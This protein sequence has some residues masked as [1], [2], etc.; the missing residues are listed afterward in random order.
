MTSRWQAAW[1]E[2][3]EAVGEHPHELS[4]LWLMGF[5]TLTSYGIARP[6]AESLFLEAYTSA[7]LPHVWVA[8]ALGAALVVAGYN[9]LAQRLALDQ[10]FGVVVGAT[11][12]LLALLLV[13]LR[14]GLPGAT[15]ALYAWKDLY[16]VVLVET[17]WI[18]ANC[19][20][21]VRAA[22]W[23]YGLFLAAGTLG[24]I[25]GAL[26]VGPLAARLGSRDSLWLVFPL[27]ALADLGSRRL[28]RYGA[29]RPEREA[30]DWRGG[31]RLLLTSRYLGLLL[32]L[33]A[34]VQL[35]ANLVDYEYN[36]VLE[37]AFVAPD[38]RTEVSGKIYATISAVAFTL[39]LASPAL[40]RYVG[41]VRTLVAVPVLIAAALASFVVAPRF[42]TMGAAKVA[43]KAFDYSLFRACKEILYIPLPYREKTQGKAMVDILTYRV[44]KGVAAG[45]VR[46]LGAV[47]AG[48]WTTG[49]SLGLTL[50]WVGLTTAIGRR[51]RTAERTEGAAAAAAAVT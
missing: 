7:R 18:Y 46:G 5:L 40:L 29:P 20:F 38:V 16:I 39:Q 4:L 27:L 37:Q 43:S 8:V 28:A 50:V 34:T 47:S 51:Y 12:S 35:V 9:R 42:A 31:L 6:A 41:V 10:V 19:V 26:A 48:G 13:A 22:R 49:L 36:R 24:E 44:A 21:H 17:F 30:T 23:L 14:A 3:R 15:F 11:L 1:G 25:T 2:L 45:V 32:L 33:V